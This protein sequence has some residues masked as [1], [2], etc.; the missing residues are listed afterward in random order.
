[1]V[2][3]YRKTLLSI[4]VNYPGKNRNNHITISIIDC[5]DSIITELFNNE[6]YLKIFRMISKGPIMTLLLDIDSIKAKKLVWK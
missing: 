1:M 6:I 3:K 5:M 2:V 4:K